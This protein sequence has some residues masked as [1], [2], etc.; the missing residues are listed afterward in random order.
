MVRGL[1]ADANAQGQVEYLVQR[2]Q[3][4][5]WAD[6]WQTLGLVLES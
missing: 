1:V 3:A 4:G 5:A 6:F 2:M